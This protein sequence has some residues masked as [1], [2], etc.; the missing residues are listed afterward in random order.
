MGI[1]IKMRTQMHFVLWS[2]LILFVLSMT[3][4]GL[5]GGVNIL[6]ELFGKIDP[7]QA[8]GAVN[9]ERITPDFFERSVSERLSYYRAPGQD[10]SDSQLRSIREETWNSI[11]QDILMQQ[12]VQDFDISVSDEEVLF[13]LRNNP[14]PILRNQPSFQTNGTFD[15][16][17]YQAALN[18]PA[19]MD[20]YPIEE[21]LRNVFI[22]YFKLQALIVSSE[23]VSNQEVIDQFNKSNSIYTID[24]LH[25]TRNALNVQELKPSEEELKAAYQEK[26]DDLDQPEKRIVSFVKW[27]KVALK[28]DTLDTFE[29]ASDVMR[30]AAAG[31]SFADL[32]NSYSEDPGNLVTADSG[33][34]GD[35]GWFVKNQMVKPFADAAFS[36]E[37][38]SV[39][40][41]VLSSFGYHVIKIKDRRTSEKGDEVNA[42]HI[43]FKI[44]MGPVSK[45]NLSK[46][47]TL[48][49][50]DSQDFTFDAAL[51]SNDLVGKTST[52]FNNLTQYISGLGEL[53]SAVRFAFRNPVGTV[54]EP[55]EN[56]RLYAVVVVDSIIP[57]GKTPFEDA[58]LSLEN[59]I[60]NKR[61][62]DATLTFANDLNNK[63]SEGIS[64]ETIGESNKKLKFI[65]NDSN[66]L[67][68]GFSAIG[69][70]NFVVGALLNAS[71]NTIVGPVETLQGHV[72]IHVKD[73]SPF[74][75][76]EFKTQKDF[77]YD[78]ILNRKKNSAFNE[79]LSEQRI[80]AEIVDNRNYYY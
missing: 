2:L 5:V 6:D 50:Y 46:Q 19:G 69:Q 56:D 72:I 8:I 61:I 13:H 38:G 37:V 45:D 79:W 21:Y 75:S 58:R 67:E 23:S 15:M 25:I 51:D 70:G 73:I 24:G 65:Q 27:D 36:A 39:V 17:K 40:G 9:G 4:G 3:I 26:L 57:E 80:N 11:I 64:F 7:G 74:D 32:A 77:I 35:L 76:L 62:M 34:G 55:F 44:S 71:K 78:T 52:S 63:I 31:N 1:M 59:E 60:L 43:L 54:S 20:W 30:L 14:P 10:I 41:P 53:R 66:T 18:D 29:N 22:P 28:R 49:S 48:F 16:S 12:A 42:S 33:R 68:K 47:A